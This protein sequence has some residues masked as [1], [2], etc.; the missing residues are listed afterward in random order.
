[1]TTWIRNFEGEVNIPASLGQ[2][3]QDVLALPNPREDAT[4]NKMPAEGPDSPA[5]RLLAQRHANPTAALTKRQD[6]TIRTD[7]WM[8]NELYDCLK[9]TNLQWMC[10]DEDDNKRYSA[11]K[12]KILATLPTP[13]GDR[14]EEKE[15]RSKLIAT[16]NVRNALIPGLIDVNEQLRQDEQWADVLNKVMR[17]LKIHRKLAPVNHAE[18]ITD[19]RLIQRFLFKAKMMERYKGQTELLN[20]SAQ[21]RA[22]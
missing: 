12:C 18:H 16:V 20:A 14:D 9:G 22:K 15:A 2:T 4:G 5:Y 21:Q 11:L 1:M 13:N 10:E 19:A 17:A 7:Q 3:V 6:A 8:G